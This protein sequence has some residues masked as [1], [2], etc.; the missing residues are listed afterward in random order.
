M[1]ESKAEQ[2]D[3]VR[4]LARQGATLTGEGPKILEAEIVRLEKDLDRAIEIARER[5]KWRTFDGF[6][7]RIQRTKEEDKE[8]DAMKGGG[9]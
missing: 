4:S 7:E 6:C 9:E 3:R 2:L 1:S 8:L 5:G